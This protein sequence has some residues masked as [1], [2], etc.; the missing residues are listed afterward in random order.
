MQGGS[1]T[2]LIEDS[3]DNLALAMEDCPHSILEGEEPTPGPLCMLGMVLQSTKQ[4]CNFQEVKGRHDSP[5]LQGGAELVQLVVQET[6]AEGARVELSPNHFS[7][8]VAER[9]KLVDTQR[10]RHEWIGWKTQ[11]PEK[12]QDAD[13]DGMKNVHSNIGMQCI[14]NV[15]VVRPG[16]PGPICLHDSS[17][18]GVEI[19]RSKIRCVPN[20]GG[21][22]QIERR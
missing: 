11:E 12:R 3:R 6:D 10:R 13:T 22:G 1:A 16:L 18:G 21:G 4:S 17:V 15:H 2:T 7:L 8:V 5:A 19:G 14:I 9:L 20:G